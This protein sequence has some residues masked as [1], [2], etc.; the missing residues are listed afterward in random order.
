[1]NHFILHTGTS[2]RAQVN[3]EAYKRDFNSRSQGLNGTVR[4]RILLRES[5]DE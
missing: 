4:A 1:M 2:K 3:D 5:Y